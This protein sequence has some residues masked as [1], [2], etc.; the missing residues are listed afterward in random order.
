MKQLFQLILKHTG[1]VRIVVA[2][3]ANAD[4]RAKIQIAFAIWIIEVHSFTVIQDDWI[5]VICGYKLLSRLLNNLNK[6]IYLIVFLLYLNF[7]YID[8][9][10]IWT[11]ENSAAVRLTRQLAAI[12]EDINIWEGNM[13]CHGA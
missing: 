5:A 2:Q 4:S 8:Y 9:I 13:H 7:K 6:W 1:I 10:H 3:T 12:P 11:T